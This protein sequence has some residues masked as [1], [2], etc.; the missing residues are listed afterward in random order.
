MTDTKDDAAPRIDYIDDAAETA[1]AIL[2]N[3]RPYHAITLILSTVLFVACYACGGAEKPVPAP[4]AS[5]S[6]AGLTIYIQQSKESEIGASV[7]SAL[8]AR[9]VQ[10]GYQITANSADDIDLIATI[11][12]GVQESKSFFT[13]YVNGQRKVSYEAHVEMMVT[14]GGI[15]LDTANV[16][17]DPEKPIP[18]D[19]LNQLASVFSG[20]GV[21]A[22]APRLLQKRQQREKE[23]QGQARLEEEKKKQE[24]ADRQKSEQERRRLDDENA[25]ISAE[26]LQCKKPTSTYS[27]N[28]IQIYLAK[29][30]NGTHNDEAREVLKLAQPALDTLQKDEN[31][32][33]RSDYESCSHNPTRGACI[34]VELYRTKYPSGIHISEANELM[35]AIH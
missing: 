11:N 32:W 23:R 34:G 10:R 12:I 24:E 28:G 6:L 17:F 33:Q 15:T 21:S 7:V 19:E 20:P 25:W 1:F 14:A 26:P 18:D 9:L 31:E 3:P 4:K 16:V 30:P 35:D 29:F 22:Q 27:C 8:Q 2:E 5:N 13:T